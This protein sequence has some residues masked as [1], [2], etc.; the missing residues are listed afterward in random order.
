M[1][2]KHL[3]ARNAV[4]SG[5]ASTQKVEPTPPQLVLLEEKRVRDLLRSANECECRCNLRQRNSGHLVD[6]WMPDFEEALQALGNDRAGEAAI[7]DLDE[8]LSLA[9]D[10]RSALQ[11]SQTNA[12]DD[13]SAACGALLRRAAALL[14]CQACGG[15]GN[16]G[17]FPCGACG[18]TGHRSF[19]RPV[20]LKGP[21]ETEAQ[22][23]E[24]GV[25]LS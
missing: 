9:R 12:D 14:D 16:D 8:L 21:E 18:Q 13:G 20:L 3:I 10:M 17:E 4:V 6:C 22:D 11:Y 23:E 2:A 1:K 7:S 19:Q 15:F 25:S 24:E 5:S